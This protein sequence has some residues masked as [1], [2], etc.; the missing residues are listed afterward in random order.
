MAAPPEN[1]LP[2]GSGLVQNQCAKVRGAAPVFFFFLLSVFIIFVVQ[3][4]IN[5]LFLHSFIFLSIHVFVR[6][7]VHSFIH[8]F[9]HSSIHSFI[10]SFI[11]FIHYQ[12]EILTYPAMYILYAVRDCGILEDPVNGLVDLSNGTTFNSVAVYSCMSIFILNGTSTRVCLADGSWSEEPPTCEGKCCVKKIKISL[13]SSY[14]VRTPP[15]CV[16]SVV[17]YFLVFVVPRCVELMAPANTLITLT[18]GQLVNSTATYSCVNSSF[19]LVGNSTT[20]R[21][22]PS[23][24]TNAAPF[25]TGEHARSVGHSYN[26]RPVALLKPFKE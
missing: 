7:F 17:M 6:S 8:S 26:T 21:C 15:S 20:R 25:C 19:I 13:S 2:R 22:T 23:G 10:H 1:A 9:I 12:C 16:I 4:F 5:D 24:W 3:S 18:D 11:S 14:P